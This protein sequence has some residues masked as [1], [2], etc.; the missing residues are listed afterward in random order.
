MSHI[1]TLR[2]LISNL[3]PNPAMAILE[4][5]DRYSTTALDENELIKLL[6][7][8]EK[9]VEKHNLEVDVPDNSSAPK[10]RMAE[11]LES[12]NDSR[13][14]LIE[15]SVTAD[16]DDLLQ[17]YEDSSKS[18]EEFG[19]A[20][21]NQS[22][23]EQIHEHLKNVRKIIE[24]SNLD[25]RKKNALFG[26]INTLA[27]EVDKEGTKTDAFFAFAGDLAFVSGIMAKRAK[28]AIDEFKAI[29]KIVLRSRAKN[30]QTALPNPQEVFLL[31]DMGDQ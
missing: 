28:P 16:V 15:N 6:L 25:D 14:L 3:N 27:S 20:K 13:S 9:L 5:A 11:L 22:E 24:E 29:L 8:I 1:K 7:F 19:F 18:P 21:L 2:S 30:E 23:K 12:I 31:S 26:R 10:D 4:I 17:K